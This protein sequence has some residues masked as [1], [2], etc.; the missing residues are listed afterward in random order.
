M[1]TEFFEKIYSHDSLKLEDFDKIILAHKRAIF[2][3]GE[4][5]LTEGKIANSYYLLEKGLCRAFVND[6]NGDEIITAFFTQGKS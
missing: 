6:P 5:L 1:K 3:K 4:L 2:S